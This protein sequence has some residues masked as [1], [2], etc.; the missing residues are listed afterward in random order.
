MKSW[1]FIVFWLI[2]LLWWWKLIVDSAVSIAVWFW[3]PMSFIWVTIVAIWTS[4]PELA[5]SLVAAFKKQTDM[6]IGWI[7]GSN[8][9]NILWILWVTWFIYPLEGYSWMSFDLTISFIASMLIFLAAFTIQKSFLTRVE[10]AVLFLLY[11]SY[12]W[13]L[14]VNV[15]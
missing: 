8:I 3:L 12:I 2:W 9:F 13:Y 7:V 4:L 14:I 11:C 6:A 1:F 5:A 15:L 10:G